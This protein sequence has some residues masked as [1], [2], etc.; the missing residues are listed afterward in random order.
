MIEVKVINSNLNK[1]EVITTE[2][3]TWG[4]LKDQ[5]EEAGLASGDYTGV[6]KE[7]STTLSLDD[8]LLPEEDFTLFIVVK[9][10]KAGSGYEDW[11]FR[12]LRAECANRDTIE[13]RSGN[14]GSST[15]MIR[16]LEEDDRTNY[17]PE[18]NPLSTRLESVLT[19]LE[20][21]LDAVDGA[22]VEAR[23]E[24]SQ[25]DPNTPSQEELEYARMLEEQL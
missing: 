12:E 19:R 23:I 20:A 13:G 18:Q 5:L 8:A 6:V 10:S 3:S 17:A 21:F 16:L 11:T 22:V 15:E 1:R 25:E 24:S 2:A 7:S 9:K 4:E 14:Y